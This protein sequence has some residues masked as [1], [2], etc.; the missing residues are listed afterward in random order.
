MIFE[1]RSYRTFLKAVLAERLAANPAY[2]MR[3]MAKQLGFSTSQLSESMSGKAN[4]SGTSLQKIAKNLRLSDG[5]SEY[6]LLLGDFESQKD[7]EIREILLRRMQRLSPSQRPITDLSVDYF[8]QIADW[9]HSAILE[10]VYLKGF[11]FTPEN[12]ARRLGISKVEADLAL[13]RLLRLEL[14]VRDENG[15]FH[16]QSQDLQVKSPEKNAAMRQFYRKIMEKASKALE[17]QTPSERWSGYETIPISLEAMPE[18]RAACDEF[19]EKV[20]RVA[21]KYPKKTEVYNLSVHFFNL[22]KEGK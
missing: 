10:M 14:L 7:P 16:R 17:E 8:K 9:Y 3:A 22:T 1:H 19:F 20:I 5:E 2:S 18:L 15:V 13:D 6:L 11:V 4:F 21:R 12:I